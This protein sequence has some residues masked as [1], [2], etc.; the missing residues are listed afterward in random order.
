VGKEKEKESRKMSRNNHS[1]DMSRVQAN[2]SSKERLMYCPADST[3]IV[4]LVIRSD[5][6]EEI[7]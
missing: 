2:C 1:R 5:K 6:Q 4:T 7:K 3:E